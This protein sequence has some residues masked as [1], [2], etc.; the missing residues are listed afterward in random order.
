MACIC[1]GRHA[2]VSVL[3]FHLKDQN[4]II[5]FEHDLIIQTVL[6]DITIHCKIDFIEMTMCQADNLI[7]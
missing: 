6:F 5:Y 7:V 2:T 1:L 4:E 3:H